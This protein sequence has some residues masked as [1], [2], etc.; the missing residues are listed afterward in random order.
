MVRKDRQTEN[1]TTDVSLASS[2]SRLYV[3]L[4]TLLFFFLRACVFGLGPVR[5]EEDWLEWLEALPQF[6]PP[7]LCLSA[8]ISD[9]R[10]FRPSVAPWPVARRSEDGSSESRGWGILDRRN[11]GGEELLLLLQRVC[12]YRSVL[13]QVWNSPG[14][15]ICYSLPRP[16]GRAAGH[17]RRSKGQEQV[18][19]QN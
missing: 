18:W 5:P 19:D 2:V 13:R 15:K 6:S 16:H 9:A 7:P 17:L 12:V 8:P 14:R 1:E 4:G 10:A 3:R 11:E